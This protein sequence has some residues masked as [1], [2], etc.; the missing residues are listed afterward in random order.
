MK[1]RKHHE[2]LTTEVRPAMKILFLSN[3]FPN[4]LQPGKG[5]F[6]KSMIESLSQIHRVHVITPVSWID[7]ISHRLK[8]KSRMDRNWMPVEYS[9]QLSVEYPRFYYPPKILHQHYGQFLSWSLY[10]CLQRTISRFQPDIILS[11]W[12]HPDG[13][14]AVKAAQEHGIPVV[15]MTG[16]S[17]VL[18][19]TQ[20]RNRKRAIQNVLQQADGVITVSNDIQNAV[21][22][23]NVHPEK[24]HTVYRGVNRDLFSPGDQRAARE[25]LG[26]PLERKIIVSVGRL[27]PVKGHSVLL[28]ACEKISKVGTRFT[29]YVL[30]DGS[31]ESA[32]L[33]KTEQTGLGE[34]FQLKGSQQ[35]HRLVDWYRAADVIALPSLSEGIPNVLLEAIS[36]GKPFVASRVGGIPEIADPTCDRLV[37]ADN[38]SELAVALAE[39][40]ES[41]TPSDRRSFEPM[42]WQ[43]SSLQISQILS[44]CS[45]RY[46][47][48]LT[49]QQKTRSSYRRKD[50][51][52]KQQT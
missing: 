45:T 24:I 49:G 11:Y 33:Q 3:V 31:L 38:S 50:K 19:L 29:C 4:P 48:G 18:L 21:K 35:Q 1:K 10:Q 25:R 20:N 36:C 34:F 16:G 28:Q 43:E 6:N 26:L 9:S 17:D 44:D 14:V 23:L 52:T 41:T 7:E 42:S 37:T 2:E 15:V 40:L 47:A 51:K 12:L 39:M 8:N 27:E 46:T 30:G 22:N 32:L 5:T 13:E